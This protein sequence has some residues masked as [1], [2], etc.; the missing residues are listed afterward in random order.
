[1]TVAPLDDQAGSLPGEGAVVIVAPPTTAAPDN[2][3]RFIES[4]RDGRARIV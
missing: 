3:G 1:M 4:L 2:A